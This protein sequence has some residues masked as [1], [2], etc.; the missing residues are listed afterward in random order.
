VTTDGRIVSGLVVRDSDQEVEL[1]LPD[2][3]RQTVKKADVESRTVGTTSPMPA[4][5]VRTPQELKDL[6]TYLLS[7]RPQPP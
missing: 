2:T 3:T 7:D 6:L 4:G 1:L 5:L